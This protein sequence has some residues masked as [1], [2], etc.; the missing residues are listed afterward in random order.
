[1]AAIADEMFESEAA[2]AEAG[3]V[4]GVMEASQDAITN[5]AEQDQDLISDQMQQAVED[6]TKNV[7]ASAAKAF[8]KYTEELPSLGGAET[9][10]EVKEAMTE[11]NAVMK[12]ED[13]NAAVKAAS[14]TKNPGILNKMRNFA[15]SMFSKSEEASMKAAEKTLKKEKLSEFK[16]AKKE[17]DEQVDDYAK[18][19]KDGTATSSDKASLDAASEKIDKIIEENPELDQEFRAAAGGRAP[20]LKGILKYKKILGAIAGLGGLFLACWLI[21]KDMTGCWQYN[22]AEPTQ[23]PKGCSDSSHCGCGKPGDSFKASTDCKPSTNE[24]AQFPFCCNDPSYPYPICTGNPGSKGSI[25]YTWKVFT[26]AGIVAGI[27]GDIKN[28]ID[29]IGGLGTDFLKQIFLWIGLGFGAIILLFVLKFMVEK[30]FSSHHTDT[31][32]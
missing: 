14:N 26:P 31:K 17:L 8:S 32:D 18:K 6:A 15:D 24:Y 7:E 10:S 29:N 28:L 25:Y 30:L 4:G 21:S 27:P 22:G 11:L 12:E 13:G 16:N 3:E 2:L 1:M 19:A 5:I 20:I 9:E 23:L